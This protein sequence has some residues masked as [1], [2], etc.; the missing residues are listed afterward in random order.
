MECDSPVLFQNETFNDSKDNEFESVLD[1]EKEMLKNEIS[2]VNNELSLLLSKM[3][4][5]EKSKF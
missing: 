3:K 2:V 1:V 4:N 5:A